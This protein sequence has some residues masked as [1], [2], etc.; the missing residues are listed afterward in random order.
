MKSN[1]N[2]AILILAAGA[3]TRMG[4]IKQLL[5]WKNTTLLKHTI[6]QITKISKDIF[7]V[8]GA[9]IEIIKPTVSDYTIIHNP[10]WEKGMGT[11]IAAGVAAI[12]PVGGFDAVLILVADQPLLTTVY[13]RKM[14]SVYQKEDCKIVATSYGNR[15]GVPAILDCSLFKE[16][17]TLN[18]DYGARRL[19]Q[20]NP[21]H[22]RIINPE[23]KAIDIDTP[24]VYEK[25]K[26]N[27]T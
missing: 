26:H 1:K 7:L 9:N 4:E 19:M 27:H 16:L 15:N 3:S 2:I 18:Q 20:E 25:L 24:E 11:S 6:S 8:L 12:E 5:P 23:G 22:I 10:D 21:E 14:I 17:K 13:Y